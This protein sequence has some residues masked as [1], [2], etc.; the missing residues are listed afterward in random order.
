[1]FVYSLYK[2][3]DISNLNTTRNK[4]FRSLDNLNIKGTVLISKEG[5]NINISQ[6]YALL[7]KAIENISKVIKL[8]DVHVN[9]TE[10]NGIAFQ[11]LKV[12]I[13]TEIIKFNY[14]FQYKNKNK[15][16][17]V[18][19]DTWNK[20][21]NNN[22]QI[23]DMRNDFEYSLGTFKNAINLGLK[24]FTDLKKRVDELNKLDKN[25]K[26]AIFCTGG[27][28]CEKAGMFLNELGFSDVYQLGG[29][30]INYLNNKQDYLW[31]G[32]CFVFDDRILLKSNS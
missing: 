29:G 16:Q 25:K 22:A 14:E 18:T 3:I 1:M 10:S 12:K 20:L 6:E 11:K 9:R 26:T 7:E 19:P 15:L 31:K 5:I 13:K 21:L 28:R 27:I 30:I 4:I 23:I 32:D 17:T 2:F 24:N 8:D